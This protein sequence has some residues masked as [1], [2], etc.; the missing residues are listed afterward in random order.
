MKPTEYQIIDEKWKS[1]KISVLMSF[2]NEEDVISKNTRE[3]YRTLDGWGLDFEIIAVDDGSDDDSYAKLQKSFKNDPRVIL[4]H[5]ERNFGKGWGLKTAFEFSSGDLILFLDA[6]LELSPFHL[7]NFLRIMDES[8]ADVVIGS[9]MHKDS[10][11]YYPLKRRIMSIVFYFMT[12][13]LFGLPVKDTQTGIKLFTREAVED[14]LPRVLVKRF[15][16]DIEL[17][18]I[19]VNHGFHIA[20]AP[21]ELNFS[22][23]AAGR[24]KISSAFNMIRDTLAVFYRF[25]ILR[26]Y[27]RPLEKNKHYRYTIIAFSQRCNDEEK[28]N[29]SALLYQSYGKIDVIHCGPN[30]MKIKNP[31]LT[32]I[33]SDSQSYS[34]RL[35]LIL[36]NFKPTC[37]Y[38]VFFSLDASIDTR[39]F[40]ASGRILSLP[41]I[42]AAS[43]YTTLRKKHGA[44]EAISFSVF[45]S[46]FY[47]ITLGYRYKSA[48][49]RYVEELP[50]SGMFVKTARVLSLPP[51]R[52]SG[53]RLEHRIARGIK[54]NGEKLYYSPDFMV[55]FRFPQN[56]HE[57]RKWIREHARSRSAYHW[58]FF[59]FSF[60]FATALIVP[61]VIG[62]IYGNP[63]LTLPLASFLLLILLTR[64]WIYGPLRG[65]KSFLLMLVSQVMYIGY[66][67]FRWKRKNKSGTLDKK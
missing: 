51:H 63:I 60:L 10:E 64:I 29:L 18:V 21:I 12:K 37:D 26:F 23:Q 34:E 59:I 16:F 9:K 31:R 27:E 52:F 40:Y 58:P 7:P 32:F 42:G 55:Y 22:R 50:L 54:E 56:F 35:K 4:V 14:S 1:K 8:Q 20:S 33:H 47:N 28:Q 2:L 66:F 43:G 36:K 3:L 15:A 6:D 5:N 57:H 30:D 24:I 19:L 49:P 39:F 44:F 48:S 13:I 41:N 62:P 38:I 25:R 65:L 17:L 46:F 45:R 61:A 67:I 53:E 11:L